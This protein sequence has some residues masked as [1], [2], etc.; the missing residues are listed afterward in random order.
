[1][2]AII[3]TKTHKINKEFTFSQHI[4]KV[5]FLVMKNCEKILFYHSDKK[6]WTLKIHVYL[7]EYHTIPVISSCKRLANSQ[8][9]PLMWNTLRF[10][11]FGIVINPCIA[12]SRY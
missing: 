7:K 12:D 11:G 8:K 4:L 2:F 1:M 10:T 9:V 6:I 5:L 3:H